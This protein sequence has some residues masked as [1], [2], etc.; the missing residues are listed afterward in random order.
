MTHKFS[1][2]ASAVL[3]AMTVF[4]SAAQACISCQYVPEVVRENT[5]AQKARP[6]A[7]DNR[8][9]L[10]ARAMK[11]RMAQE[12]AAKEQM[13][14]STAIAASRR[15][16][17]L[18]ARQA[19]KPREVAVVTAVKGP[20]ITGSVKKNIETA[21][22]EPVVVAKADKPVGCKK[23]DATTGVTLDVSCK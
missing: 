3:A 17:A 18:S 15:Q 4:A 13:A 10:E 23:F 11:L 2:A 14:R 9:A 21:S 5:T 6:I 20:L 8:Y 19:T 12:R 16:S 22:T 1:V 7:Q